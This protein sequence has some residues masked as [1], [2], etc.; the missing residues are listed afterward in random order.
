MKQRV[1]ESGKRRPLIIG[2]IV[3]GVILVIAAVVIAMALFGGLKQ[4][5]P[6]QAEPVRRGPM[7][8]HVSADGQALLVDDKGERITLKDGG[9]NEAAQSILTADGKHII[10]QGTDGSLY[11]YDGIGE[12]PGKIDDNALT[13]GERF[14]SSTMMVYFKNISGSGTQQS[15]DFE[16]GG[17]IYES[18][19]Q[20]D[21]GLCSMGSFL[22]TDN[23]LLFSQKGEVLYFDTTMEAPEKIAD[24][25]T[26]DYVQFLGASEGGKLAV[27]YTDTAAE[28]KLYCYGDKKVRELGTLTSSADMQNIQAVFFNNGES[29]VV[30]GGSYDKMIISDCGGEPFIVEGNMLW[31][32]GVLG[33]A[34]DWRLFYMA[35][36]NEQSDLY[37][38]SPGKEPELIFSNMGGFIACVEDAIYYR[39]MDNRLYKAMLDSKGAVVTEA[40]AEDVSVGYMTDSG[41]GILV[42]KNMSGDSMSYENFYYSAMDSLELKP[43][44]GTVYMFAFSGDDSGI[45]YISRTQSDNGKETLVLYYQSFDG[46]PAVE[47]DKDVFL[48]DTKDYYTNGPGVV[49]F[50]QVLGENAEDNRIEMYTYYSGEKRLIS[51]SVSY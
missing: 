26:E 32:G 37:S 49:Y 23:W 42:S 51:E 20:I 4:T 36:H 39:D 16:L 21:L 25:D 13:V 9:Q 11:L 34:H 50:K 45:F 35:S 40:I 47:I 7:V 24:G 31:A 3:C 38:I 14:V 29:V 1:H 5:R 19:R 41:N 10:V 27:W 22:L 44:N 28:R 8:G 17:Y 18:D 6:A 12:N 30:H 48:M 2:G 33:D 43:V 15:S 46:S